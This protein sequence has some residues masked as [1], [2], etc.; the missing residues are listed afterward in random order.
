MEL[1]GSEG[2]AHGLRIQ[3]DQFRQN[4]RRVCRPQ[5]DLSSLAA[6]AS[7]K[8]PH[9]WISFP[10]EISCFNVHLVHERARGGMADA[11]DLGSGSE[12]IGGSSPLARTILNRI[13][14]VAQAS[15]LHTAI[16]CARQRGEQ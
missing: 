8:Q 14:D 11:P 15:R 6:F 9:L 10:L 13:M 7:R 16:F 2:N 12:R 1:W 3:K 4:P 5:K